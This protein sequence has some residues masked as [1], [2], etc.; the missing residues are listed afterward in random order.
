MNYANMIED[1]HLKKTFIIATVC[2]TLVGTFTSS[3]G[4]YE[5][6]KQ[7]QKQQK[8]DISQDDEIKKLKEQVERSEKREKDI[9]RSLDRTKDDVEASFQRSGALISREY[10]EGYERLGR[11]FAVG[12]VVTENKLQAQVI[13]MQQTVINVLQDALY[14]D[15]PLDRKDM[16]KLVAASDATREGALHALRQ[17]RQRLLM[18]PEEPQPPLPRELPPPQRA[19]PPPQRAL[20]PPKPASRTSSKA[21]SRAPSRAPSKVPSRAQSRAPSRAPSEV[22]SRP[23]RAS[24]IVKDDPLYCRYSFDLQYVQNRPLFA[25]FAPGGDCQCPACGV[26]LDVEADDCWAIGKRVARFIPVDGYEREIE[27]E[28]EYIVTPRFV[29]KCHTPEG[30]Y[31]CLLCS[32]YRD[33]DV[34]CETPDVLVGHIGRAHDVS[35]LDREPDFRVRSVD[36]EKKRY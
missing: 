33:G 24:T 35:E 28:V 5:R 2:S 20:P 4:L 16:A 34:I 14:H 32:R 7:T 3:L 6:I 29:V 10:E 30:D 18:A 9:E 22:P 36:L 21:P 11:K 12:D 31:A 1:K 8:R 13:A 23:S 15:R 19:L 26:R 27:E 17:Q 25:S